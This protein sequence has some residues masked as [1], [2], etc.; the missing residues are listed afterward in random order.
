MRT[1]MTAMIKFAVAAVTALGCGG[2]ARSV[3][4]Y[5]ADTEKLL[6]TRSGAIKSCYDAALSSDTALAG[7]VT[8]KFTVEKKTG[9]VT[10]STIE[11]TKSSAPAALGNCILQALA[12]LVLDPPDRNDGEATFIYEFKPGAT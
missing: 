2:T 6:E 1:T 4:V 8:V 3:D 12:G 5:R 7:I 11:N 10:K 9:Q